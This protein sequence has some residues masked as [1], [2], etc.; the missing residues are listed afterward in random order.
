MKNTAVHAEQQ[1]TTVLAMVRKIV[2]MTGLA[3]GALLLGACSS[4]S[5]TPAAAD[6]TAGGEPST[7]A[8]L[9]A[10]VPFPTLTDS[11]SVTFYDPVNDDGTQS[12]KATVSIAKQAPAKP[13]KLPRM[14][15]FVLRI[16]A[17]GDQPFEP[18]WMTPTFVAKSGQVFN[19]VQSYCG[20]DDVSTIDPIQPGQFVLS[21]VDVGLPDQAGVIQ[22]GEAGRGFQIEVPAAQ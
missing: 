8:T 1:A 3:A 6:S 15:H 2:V 7:A 19:H 4:S 22:F 18:S 11:N 21:C 17:I 13:W 16:A 10:Y 20:G 9:P 5:E 14:Q 12:G